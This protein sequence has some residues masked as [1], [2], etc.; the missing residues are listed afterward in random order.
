MKT[1]IKLHTKITDDPDIGAMPLAHV[2][3][4]M[5]LLAL[6]GK[7]DDRQDDVE[8]GKLDTPGRIAW[9]LR[10]DL[11]ELQSALTAFIEL[12]MIRENEGILY[13][14]KYPQYQA[15]SP[16][17]SRQ[18]VRKRV[19]QYRARTRNGVTP[20]LP[21]DVTR[22]EAEK[23]RVEVEAEAV[24]TEVTIKAAATV[25]AFENS[26]GLQINPLEYEQLYD[27]MDDYTPEWVIAAIR[28]ATSSLGGK[29]VS[30]RYLD[31]IL[32]R[33]KAEGFRSPFSGK[34]AKEWDSVEW[35]K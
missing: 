10:R 19:Q 31:A 29:T 7:I 17:A 34:A 28:E 12:G 21:S 15:R 14:A 6:A 4:W 8:S 26:R 33:W 22:L 35:L 30:I 13:I 18:A 24:E 32:K 27:L 20:S 1:W 25:K 3:V 23:N 16:S 11:D 9:Y 2:G 5:L